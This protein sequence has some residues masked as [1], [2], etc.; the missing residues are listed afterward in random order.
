MLVPIEKKIVNKWKKNCTTSAIKKEKGADC[1][2]LPPKCTT[3]GNF[4][5][6]YKLLYTPN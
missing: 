4:F 6:N 3:N 1:K 5:L 2:K